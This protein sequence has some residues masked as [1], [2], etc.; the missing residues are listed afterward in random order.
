MKVLLI[1]PPC[2][3]RRIHTED[4][5]VPPIGLYY[6]GAA[7]AEAGHEVEVISLHDWDG[8]P[9]EIR[10]LMIDKRPG[11]IGMS[12]LNA[13]RWGGIEVARIAKSIDPE[14]AVAFGGP[15]ATLLSDHFLNHFPEIDYIV[16]GE[17]E[18]SFP[19]LVNHL[20]E[21]KG[22]PPTDVP[23][24]AYRDGGTIQKTMPGHKIGDL[25]T[26]PNP[27]RYFTYS[28]VVLT[29]GCPEACA[30]CG[31]PALWGRR[32]RSHS[33]GYFVDQM[34]MLAERGVS[35]FHVSDDVFTLRPD[36]TVAV[37]R[38]ILDRG[39]QVTWAAISRVDRVDPEMLGWMRRAGCVQISFG[40]E[41][42]SPR[43]R[44]LLNKRIR[45]DDIKRAFSLTQHYGILARAYFIYG[46]P[47]ETDET[48]DETLALISEIRPLATIFYLLSL[49][50]GTALYEGIRKGTGLSDEIWCERIEDL[51][52]CQLDPAL[53]D[54][55]VREFG[56]KLRTG[57]HQRL[58]GFVE[59]L[60]LAD[61]PK[62]YPFHADFLSRLALTFS[63]GDYAGIP[64]VGDTDAI[65]EGL[66]RRA[67]TYAP[68]HRAFVGLG[69][70]RQKRGDLRAA[71][72]II[73]EGLAHFPDSAELRAMAR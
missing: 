28:H 50:P 29:R 61:D 1:Y 37:C 55:R 11:I 58:A 32:V 33:P 9:A 67:L 63:H 71:A 56:R 2:L 45:D 3:E 40:V 27:A 35:F 51:L 42:G 57:F 30:F 47:G 31:S 46:C 13:N 5:S 73:A 16:F 70:L 52:Y 59:S 69:M 68:D 14:L 24:I 19:A 23:G 18:R 62:L 64:A 39:L 20:A 54:E 44:K 7:L 22:G 41:S 38:E 49:F 10:R 48:I 15:S 4:V 6:V 21:G 34:A 8:D 53:P 72:E 66:H 17:G 60:D 12:I 25:D 65:A 43:I 36:R 26:L